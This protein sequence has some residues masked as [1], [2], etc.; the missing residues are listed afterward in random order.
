MLPF[1]VEPTLQKVFP[2]SL[3]LLFN[4]NFVSFAE[5]IAS[6]L[7]GRC[8]KFAKE[9]DAVGFGFTALDFDESKLIVKQVCKLM[10]TYNSVK[11]FSKISVFTKSPLKNV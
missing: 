6:S 5:S 11:A 1:Y 4:S 9:D 10:N 2:L 3:Q 7:R 8:S